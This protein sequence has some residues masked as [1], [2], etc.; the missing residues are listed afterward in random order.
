MVTMGL[1]WWLSGK[2]S[3]CNVGSLGQEEPMEK[4][5]ATYYSIL[6]WRIPWI[7]EPG[8]HP[9]SWTQLS[10]KSWKRG[11]HDGIIALASVCPLKDEDKRLV[12][13]S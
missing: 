9:K 5:M 11:P 2:E 6:A 8:R 7:R 3:T 10:T 13:A 1:S 4:E 12:Q